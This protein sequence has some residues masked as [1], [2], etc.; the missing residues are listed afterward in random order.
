MPVSTPA[1]AAAAAT[2][3]Y[4]RFMARMTTVALYRTGAGGNAA[5]EAYKAD[6]LRACPDATPAQYQAAM[7]AAARAAGV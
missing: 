3:P 6:F 4:Q 7:R 2:T 1:R 5:Y